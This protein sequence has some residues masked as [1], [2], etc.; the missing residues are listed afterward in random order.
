MSITS[1]NKP[2]ILLPPAVGYSLM[3]LFNLYRNNNISLR[4]YPRLIVLGLI[5]LINLPFRA[6]ERRFINPR[7]KKLEITENPIFIVGH[8]RSGT[9]YLHNLLSQDPQMGYTTTFQSVFPD[10]VFNKLGRFIFLNFTKLLIPGRR[11]G[12]NVSLNPLYPQ[13]EEFALGAKIPISFYY[14]WMFPTKIVSYYDSFVRF[15]DIKKNQ[16]D[17]WKSDYKLLIKKALKNTNGKI[18]LSKNPPNTG[19][20]KILL[21]MFPNAKFIHIHRNPIEVFL[22][23]CNFYKKMMPPL[24]LQNIGDDRNDANIIEIYKSIMNDFFY[25]KKLIPEGNLLEVAYDEL[26][27]NP[28]LILKDIYQQF[29]LK[30]YNNAKPLFEMYYGSQRQYKKNIHKI[31]NTRLQKI[32]NEWSHTITEYNYKIPENVEIIDA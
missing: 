20:I 30:G 28:E 4:Y 31:S 6:Y 22:S 29:G 26:E 25:Q 12:D 2:G 16:A 15:A 24:Q 21:E 9:T 7:I 8:W 14:F 10:T 11:K 23:T 32:I 17:D 19:R 13:E 3:I 18:Y 27:K 5:N 1:N